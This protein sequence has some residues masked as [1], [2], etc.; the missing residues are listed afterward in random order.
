MAKRHQLVRKDSLSQEQRAGAVPAEFDEINMDLLVEMMLPTT[1]LKS[2]T[3]LRM[4][5]EDE[6][7]AAMEKAMRGTRA[8]FFELYEYIPV[9][10]EPTGVYKIRREPGPLI[11][12]MAE[13]FVFIEVDAADIRPQPLIVR[14]ER[15]GTANELISPG[16]SID[17]RGFDL[18]FDASVQDE[19]VYLINVD[20]G[21]E[22]PLSGDPPARPDDPDAIQEF[23]MTTPGDLP[24]GTYRLQLRARPDAT[25]LVSGEMPHR[26]RVD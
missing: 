21:S 3:Q 17:I 5:L 14:D 15:T 1:N 20:S 24:H 23:K 12:E 25:H 10:L 6:M 2:R 22:H 26:L 16:G 4:Q 7:A 19:G 8:S 11:R 18:N 13:E 9:S